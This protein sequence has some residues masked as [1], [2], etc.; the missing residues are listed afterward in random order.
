MPA[1]GNYILEADIDNWDVPCGLEE[2]F[3]TSAVATS[4][5]IITVT[6]DIDT[7]AE[8]S[9]TTTGTLPD[10]LELDTLYY[11]I[12]VSSVTIKVANSPLLAALGTQVDL[13][14]A[15]TGTH[16]IRINWSETF[17]TT[18]VTLA[19]DKIT[20]SH[21]IDDACKLRFNSS[22][23]TPDLPA[24]LVVGVAYYAINVDPTHVQVAT[25]PA[26]AIAGTNITITDVGSGTH[27]LFVGE[28][29]T[30]YDRQQ[31]INRVEDLIEKLT[32]DF[33]YAEDFVIYLDG[34]GKDRL[35]L[36]LVPDIISV[37]KV[38]IS[39]VEL[40]SSWYTFDN[41]S[42]YLDPEA[43]TSEEGDMAELHLRLKY[44]R[45]LFPR[46]MGNIKVTGTY[47]KSTVPARVRQA[48]IILCKA[49]N[50]P[51]LYPSYDS[52]LKSEK[53]GDYSYTVADGKNITKTGID[54]VDDLLREYLRK[55]PMLGAV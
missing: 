54:A 36:G 39:G 10:G 53:I 13:V 44:E 22:G 46:G 3:A 41:D 32:K 47:G 20:V 31:A 6:H 7:G 25:T 35:F 50:D 38:K 52:N 55:K 37:S 33:F 1:S 42:I 19:S 34:N 5:D 24:P 26:N 15:G 16:T 18:D 45:I 14:D 28:G 9:F 23:S 11:V 29:E 40:T 51:E 27:S 30:E 21:D 17:A 12:N 48:A 43:V 4:T 2:E 49:E 8:V